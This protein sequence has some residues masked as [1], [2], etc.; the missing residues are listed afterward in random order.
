MIE[1]TI[2][3]K[4]VLL[5]QKRQGWENAHYD[6]SLDVRIA[7]ILDDDQMKTAS[8]ARM[9]RALK[10]LDEV[11]KMITELEATNDGAAV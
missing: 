6:A 4:L 1:P 2:A 8:L 5:Q 3:V 9:K 10:A 11:D 7:G